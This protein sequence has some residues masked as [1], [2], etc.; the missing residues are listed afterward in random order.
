MSEWRPGNWDEAKAQLNEVFNRLQFTP[1][2]DSL[3][4]AGADTMLAALREGGLHL[5]G[6]VVTDNAEGLVRIPLA[7]KNVPQ[8][9]VIISDDKRH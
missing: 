5:S 4:E 6:G 1:F 2:E 7:L 8:T 3:I 9:I